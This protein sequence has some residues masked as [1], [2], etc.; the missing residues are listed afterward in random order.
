MHRQGLGSAVSFSK[1]MII[2]PFVIIMNS[3]KW[4]I[5]LVRLSVK[6]Y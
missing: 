4:R 2:N 5:M 6:V 3:R 1:G